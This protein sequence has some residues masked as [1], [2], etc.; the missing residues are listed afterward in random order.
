MKNKPKNR[1]SEQI[2]PD[3][4]EHF[5]Y[6]AGYT[7]GGAPY[8][9]TWE[10]MEAV[11]RSATAP[12]SGNPP[13]QKAPVSLNDIVQEMQ[14]IPDTIT[15]YFKRSTGEFIAVTD[16]YVHAAEEGEPFDDRPEWE[17]EAIR[18]TADVLAHE[19][20]GDYIPWP[21]RY[22][23][24]EHSFMEGFCHSVSNPKIANDLLRSISG[25]GAFRRFRDAI[26]RHG[27]VDA[28][29]RFKDEAYREIAREWC[30][31]NNIN[32]LE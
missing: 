32:W 18:M 6:I 7:S 24:H 21:S 1:T 22:D 19:N 30:E 15:V 17:Q 10:E 28:W 27:V 9:V 20:D 13:A 14:I 5:A 31:E 29:H 2:A 26:R 12:R 25:K 4:D 3:N 8:G 11:E 16:E 23:I